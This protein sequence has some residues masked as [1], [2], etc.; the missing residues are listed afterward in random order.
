VQH[1][2]V[3][4]PQYDVMSY[5]PYMPLAG[6]TPA[7][8]RKEGLTVNDYLAMLPPAETALLQVNLGYFLGSVHYTTL[9]KYPFWHFPDHRVNAPQ[10][11]FVNE[12]A[13]IGQTIEVRNAHRRPYNTLAPAGI[14]QSI[15]I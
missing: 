15:N 7:P 13:R 2:A 9:G 4:F 10:A 5:V 3:N 6:Y 14:P 8:T 11:E 1:A 12:L